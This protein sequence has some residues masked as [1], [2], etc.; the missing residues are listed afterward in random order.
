M[1][2]NEPTPDPQAPAAVYLVVDVTVT[3]PQLFQQ[4][5]EGHPASVA[6]YGGRFLSAAGRTEVIEGDWDPAIL[7]IHEWPS[8]AAFHA[9]Y[10]SEE[11]RPWHEIRLR[12]ARINAILAD[13]L[14][15]AMPSDRPEGVGDC[16]GDLPASAT[17][18]TEAPAEELRLLREENARLR[19]QLEEVQDEYSLLRFLVDSLPDFVSYVDRDLH[20]RFCN[21]HYAEIT[22]RPAERMAGMHV[23]EVLG[24]EALVHIQPHVEQALRGEF[25]CYEDYVHYRFGENQY[26][27]VR[28]VPRVGPDSEVRG[29]GV[30]VRNITAQKEA[31]EAALEQRDLL[32]SLINA[33]PDVVCLKDGKGHWLLA[34]QAA[35]ALFDLDPDCYEG[36]ADHE[37]VAAPQAPFF[38]DAADDEA[39]W[40]GDKVRRSDV[41]CPLPGGEMRSFDVIQVPLLHPD[42]RRR[43][44]VVVGRDVTELE[45]ARYASDA[46]ARAKGRFLA[47]VSHEIRT[48]LNA[49][50]GFSRL[51]LNAR[52]PERLQDYLHQIN[53]S[54]EL[55]LRLINDILDFSR[56]DADKLPLET[57]PFDLRELVEDGVWMVSERADTKNLELILDCD[58]DL[59]WRLRGDSLRLRQVLSNLLTNAV[60]FTESGEV[61]LR[62]SRPDPVGLPSRYLFEVRDTGIGIA[63]E[64]MQGLFE[65]FVQA[66]SSHIGRFG[67]TGLGLSISKRLVEL[68]GGRIEV[69]SSPGCGAC[70]RVHLDL[71]PDPTAPADTG[72]GF[73]G[74]AGLRV[75]LVD[76]HRVARD[77]T[78]RILTRCGA[79]VTE[80]ATAAD[81]LP[82]LAGGRF[83]QVWVDL[84]LADMGH[85]Q[86]VRH[87]R[88]QNGAR[89]VTM[90][91]PTARSEA[92]DGSA[93]VPELI[94]KPVTLM[95]VRRLLQ[96]LS[97]Q[98]P[99][100][101]LVPA[102]VWPPPEEVLRHLRGARVLL[103][104]DL[105]I[106][107]RVAVELL[108]SCGI[109]VD[110]ADHGREAIRLL[111]AQAER[112]DLVL[113]D[114]QMPEMDGYE[115]VRAVREEL[116]LADLPVVG[117][118]AHALDTERDRGLASGMN[119]YLIKPID[120]ER[121]LGVLKTWIAPR[122]VPAPTGEAPAAAIDVDGVLRTLSGNRDLFLEIVGIFES[123]YADAGGRLDRHLA[124]GDLEAAAELA[125]DLKGTSGSLGAMALYEASGALDDELRAGTPSPG[126][127]S[128]FKAAL[129][130]VLKE[131]EGYRAES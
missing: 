36:L 50:L 128:R 88:G 54:A 90:A 55:L 69:E 40:A 77:A 45:Q 25:V 18:A 85:A 103:V 78:R 68:M 53:S 126:T 2:V 19:A 127:V 76:D 52:S 100:P 67:G 113:M 70:F 125:H 95:G 5:V 108:E 11:Y 96:R 80:A 102:W 27:D 59:P 64:D 8:R 65:P 7:V 115:T 82:A 71:E 105:P 22:G 12:S 74:L 89:V 13:G 31:E 63:A 57:V 116:R 38:Q 44:L 72:W 99:E 33:V 20:Y 106:N 24:T 104:E 107:Q 23:S 111:A 9:W 60:K 97:G 93:G 120:P 35:V 51:V 58:W 73:E 42:G 47:N 117:L 130:A 29:F 101:A 109:H 10:R 43:H 61:A 98:V 129:G 6:R 79:E 49:I 34:N 94:E 41:K 83:D 21:R 119:D 56:L 17:Q 14:P 46:A 81:A 39:L 75:L 62:V 26:V 118:T 4:Y 84:R 114:I 37:L 1:P 122:Q 112:Y 86:L 92:D 121:L 110:V 124:E 32:A 15:L 28:Y 30:V 87:I 131:I 91:A 16:P 3:D 66:H 123:T 48:P